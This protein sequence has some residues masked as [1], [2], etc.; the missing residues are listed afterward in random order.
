MHE[1]VFVC[2]L[3]NETWT[4]AKSDATLVELTP[5][6]LLNSQSDSVSVMLE[7]D[8]IAILYNAE[9]LQSSMFSDLF[10]FPVIFL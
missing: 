1:C 8:E 5:S 4:D 7:S 2:R 9:V 3:Q 6:P 10:Y